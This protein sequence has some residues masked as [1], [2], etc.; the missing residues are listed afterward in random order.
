[1]AIG[2]QKQ[3]L[4]DNKKIKETKPT[5]VGVQGIIT[6]K[7]QTETTAYNVGVMGIK[8][9][10]KPVVA[11]DPK[12]NEVKGIFKSQKDAG[13]NLGVLTSKISEV[14]SGSRKQSKGLSFRVPTTEEMA[15]FTHDN[16]INSIMGNGK[17]VEKGS[18]T[19]KE[20]QKTT[21]EE[22]ENTPQTAQAPANPQDSWNHVLKMHMKYLAGGGEFLTD[23]K[24]IINAVVKRMSSDNAAPG[25]TGEKGGKNEPQK[26]EKVKDE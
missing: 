19:K 16:T 20:E 10:E 21:T 17:S 15:K 26:E 5:N 1:M 9:T 12:T 24:S 13:A 7:E 3:I 23:G 11:F 14:M 8:P 4:E 6:V 22:A 18:S 2:L 25:A